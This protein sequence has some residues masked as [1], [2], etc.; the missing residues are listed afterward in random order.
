VFVNNINVSSDQFC[1]SV[2]TV[3]ADS[4]AVRAG[5]VTLAVADGHDGR[6]LADGDPPQA[7]SRL[8]APY[9]YTLT[10]HIPQVNSG[11]MS[12]FFSLPLADRYENRTTQISKYML[13][14]YLAD[15][16]FECNET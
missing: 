16:M 5:H 3:D 11:Y 6:R 9:T 15:N 1:W 10:A 14:M 7:A 4:L 12:R 13:H 8:H 2:H